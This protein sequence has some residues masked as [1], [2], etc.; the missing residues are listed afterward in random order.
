MPSRIIAITMRVVNAQG[1]NEPRDAISHDWI[2][3]LQ[4]EEFTPLLVPNCLNDPVGFVE[5]AGITA[6]LLSNGENVHPARYHVMGDT[7]GCSPERDETEARLY[8]WA[9][10]SGVR[11][12]AVC[13]GFQF[14]NVMQRGRLVDDIQKDVAG[15]MNH[16]ATDHE[17]L[18]SDSIIAGRVGG[19]TC[20][21]NSYHRQGVTDETLGADLI[22]FARTAGGIIEAFR[23]KSHP[24]LG[25][26]W[27]PE[28]SG[29]DSYCHRE[30]AMQ[31]LN[32]GAWWL[33][34]DASQ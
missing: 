8:R 32:E 29:P 25:I 1:Y 27:H 18:I 12:L 33:N 10:A 9:L 14:V 4:S 2:N 17:I 26:Q 22:P 5:Q 31:F 16:V 13:R 21:V 20:S 24:M 34:E 30:L 11:V 19:T 3:L 7:K 23:M 6:L 15:G 28:R